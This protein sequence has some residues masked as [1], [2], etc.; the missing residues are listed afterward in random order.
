MIFLISRKRRN[1]APKDKPVI[2]KNILPESVEAKFISVDDPLADAVRKSCY[3]KWNSNKLKKPSTMS[4]DSLRSFAP[5]IINCRGNCNVNNNV[6]A[7]SVAEAEIEE[8]GDLN[9]IDVDL[10][11]DEN[12]NSISTANE[13]MEVDVAGNVNDD[14]ADVPLSIH[15]FS[16]QIQSQLMQVIS[17]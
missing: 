12:S 16:P 5:G 2:F 10:A 1:V 9:P 6:D 4:W 15:S 17:T 3:V 14:I 13:L 7:A 11:D 8:I